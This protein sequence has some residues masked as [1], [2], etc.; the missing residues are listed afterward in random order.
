[1]SNC[2]KYLYDYEL[3]EKFCGCVIFS[4]KSNFHKNKITR[5][6]CRSG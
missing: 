3:V 4:L 5:H 2:I 1:M 6:R